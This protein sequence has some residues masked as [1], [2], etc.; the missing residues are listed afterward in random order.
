MN[1]SKVKVILT[2]GFL[3]LASGCT[4]SQ[5]VKSNVPM[6][7]VKSDSA[8]TLSLTEQEWKQKLTP[9]QFYILRQKGTE[10]PF[11][12]K[13]LMHKEQGYYTCAACGHQLFRSNAKFDSHC[14]WPSFDEQISNGAIITREDSSHGMFRVEILC[15]N[16][17][18]HLGHIFDDGPTTTGKRYCVN[19]L[20]LEFEPSQSM[21]QTLWIT[22]D[23]PAELNALLQHVSGLQILG[24][25]EIENKKAMGWELNWETGTISY[26]EL[27]DIMTH[28]KITRSKISPIQIQI[29]TT[30][31]IPKEEI[32][33]QLW[34]IETGLMFKKAEAPISA[35]VQLSQELLGWLKQD[36]ANLYKE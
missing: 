14:G 30:Q 34:H 15:G 3:W 27:T 16:C 36:F 5:V 26:R 17:G 29:W 7:N 25:G 2:S 12:G 1:N 8:F 9:D 19:S 21:S 33:T 13:F 35:P 31:T 10:R 20:S 23:A 32:N 18:G 22:S 28:F 24:W 4:Q 6:G 11:T